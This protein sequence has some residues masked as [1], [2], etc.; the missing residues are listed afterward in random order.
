[1]RPF[2]RPEAVLGNRPTIPC[3]HDAAFGKAPRQFWELDQP[4]P[5]ST[6]LLPA[7]QLPP[8]REDDILECRSLAS[9]SDWHELMSEQEGARSV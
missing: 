1:M 8:S 4:S 9:A 6:K 2:E 3:S 5:V 7:H